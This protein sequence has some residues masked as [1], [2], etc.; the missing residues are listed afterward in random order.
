M[1]TIRS[2]AA[3]LLVAV[4]I[5]G[6]AQAAGA[7]SVYAASPS[8]PQTWVTGADEVRQALRWDAA[9]QTLFADVKYSTGNYSDNTHPTQVDDFALAFPTVRLDP[10]T[11]ALTADG[12]RIGT[13]RDGLLG[14]EVRLNPGVSLDIHRHH[15]VVVGRIIRSVE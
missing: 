4:A 8:H 9:R 6:S 12:V 11:K 14:Q 1:K 10:Q 15:G 13:L 3:A 2:L 5:P 7:V